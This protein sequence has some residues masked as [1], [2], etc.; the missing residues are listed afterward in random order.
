LYGQII[1]DEFKFDEL[2]GGNQWW[3]NK[4]AFQT[5]AKYINA[6][7]IDQLDLQVEYNQSRPFNYS[8]RDSTGSYS[9]FNQPLAHPLGSNFQEFVLLARYRPTKRISLDGR[10]FLIATSEDIDSI[11][12]GQNILR[13]NDDRN[14]D[15]G[16]EQGQGTGVN[17][18]VARL[19]ASYMIKQNLF[20]DARY[21]FRRYDSELDANDL[22]TH[23][24]SLGIRWNL[25]RD[26]TE[27]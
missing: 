7:G 5:G 13:P 15:Y 26:Q 18:F 6:F 16:I 1:F 4:F 3:G 10:L 27:F 22:K 20:L 9:H 11:S 24:L 19:Q 25:Y 17:T 21:F 8:H 14:D 23:Y 2:F 12:Y